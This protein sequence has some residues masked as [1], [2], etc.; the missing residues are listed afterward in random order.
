M[1]LSVNTG[2]GILVETR[3]SRC[4]RSICLL[5]TNMDLRCKFL[6][7]LLIRTRSDLNKALK[8]FDSLPHSFVVLEAVSEGIGQMIA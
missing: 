1:F 6:I 2:S 7:G 8:G 3:I 4:R 5:S